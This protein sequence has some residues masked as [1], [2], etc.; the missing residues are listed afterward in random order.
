MAVVSW[1]W[2]HL[3]NLRS[4]AQP[5]RAPDLGSGG[6]ESES[7]YSETVPVSV[8]GN[9]QRYLLTLTKSKTL[10]IFRQL[11]KKEA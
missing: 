2:N 11:S 6:R 8:S 3:K 5:G 9:S 1:W 10:E 7:R 4:I